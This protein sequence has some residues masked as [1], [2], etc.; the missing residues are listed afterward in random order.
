M[1][2]TDATLPVDV[3][4]IWVYDHHESDGKRPLLERGV[5]AY[6]HR[7]SLSDEGIAMARIR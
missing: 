2:A 5:R 7:H 1:A 3:A 6:F 4:M